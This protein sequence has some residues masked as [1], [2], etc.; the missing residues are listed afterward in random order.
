[1]EYSQK[2]RIY[3]TPEQENQIQRTFGCSRFVYNYFLAQ[4]IA[5]YKDEGKSLS[6]YEQSRDLTQLKTNPDY[7][8]L[9]EV[10][11]SPL[12]QTL[13]NLDS[14]YRNFFRRVKQ[15]GKPGFP[16]F[17]RKHDRNKSYRTQ[18]ASLNGDYVKIPKIG[19]V[20]CRGAK[21]VEGRILS[22]TVS[23][24]PSGKYY[25]SLN[26]TDVDIPAYKPTGKMCG[27]DIGIK[28]LAITSDGVK[29]PNHKYLE[30]STKKLVKLQRQLSRKTKGSHR[31]EKQRL[32]VA[33]LQEH[34]ANQRRDTIQKA[35]T[36]LIRNYDLICMED[37]N[38]SGM[39]KNHHLARAI[40]DASF[41]EFKR[42]LEYKA[43]WRGRKVAVIDRFYPSSQVCSVCGYQN[44]EVKNLA[45][46]SWVCPQCG[47][48]H[49]RDINAATNILNEGLRMLA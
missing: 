49:D 33:R 34:I 36:E 18:G 28:D 24:N 38:V 26:Y 21:Q 42:E 19:E 2:F 43:A 37:L 15:G 41:S 14:A 31:W 8:W 25:V 48:R 12:V 7:V 29:L 9:S 4:R 1:M 45:V 16:K 5:A 30:A 11:S 23:Q 13:R 6:M 32:K 44:K 35:T 20:L 10:A 46:R 27:V 40:A 47:T 39:M 22:A 17:K 3:P